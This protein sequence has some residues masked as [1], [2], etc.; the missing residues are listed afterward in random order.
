MILTPTHARFARPRSFE[1]C[2][3]LETITFASSVKTIG[4]YAFAGCYSLLELINQLDNVTTIRPFA[5][6]RCTSL[7]SIIPFPPLKVVEEFTFFNCNALGAVD[8][9]TSV[10]NIRE[11]AFEGCTR[12]TLTFPKASWHLSS[13]G[14]G[15]NPWSI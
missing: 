1:D 9:P 6:S 10:M 5:F 15:V 4:E 13:I 2:A 11:G 7:A 14:W 12:L 8:I 3:Q